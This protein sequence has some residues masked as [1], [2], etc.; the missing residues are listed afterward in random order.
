[1][2][3]DILPDG[4]VLVHHSGDLELRADAVG[5][6]DQDHILASW[7]FMQPA[8]RADV[9]D[10]VGG[11]CRSDHLLDGADCVHLDIDVDAR[12]C[13]RRLDRFLFFGHG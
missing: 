8:E 1:M 6:S 9:A 13:V 5:R 2:V 11:L 12:L 4:V 10:Y 3:D 7:D